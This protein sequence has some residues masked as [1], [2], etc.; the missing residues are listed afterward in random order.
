MNRHQLEDLADL[1]LG[2]PE[3]KAEIRPITIHGRV[4][5]AEISVGGLDELAAIEERGAILV[6]S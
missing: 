5:D 2:E 3:A 6:V 4:D 1:L